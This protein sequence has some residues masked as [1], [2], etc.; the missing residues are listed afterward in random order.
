MPDDTGVP[1]ETVERVL[2]FVPTWVRAN[3]SMA[4]KL[5]GLLAEDFRDECDGRDGYKR[6]FD[7]LD[8]AR[9]VRGRDP[10]NQ[11]L[12]LWS[13]LVLKSFFRKRVD[14][15]E[16]MCHTLVVEAHRGRTQ[17]R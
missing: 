4:A 5:N 3:A 2:G 6:F 15:L 8:V 9:Q 16:V 17:R 14:L 11:S 13:R 1:T 7:E 10:V 12:Y